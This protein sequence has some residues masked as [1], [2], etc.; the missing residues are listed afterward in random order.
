MARIVH[1]LVRGI[2]ALLIA[3]LVGLTLAQQAGPLAPS[4]LELTRFLPYPAL[5]GPAL[6]ALLLA[7]TLGWRWVLASLVTL[8]L[9][10]TLAMGLAWGR[11]QA[12]GT[13][14]R[15]MT[16]NIKAYKAL[17]RD[18]GFRELAREVALHQPDI[19]VTQDSHG[20]SRAQ[21]AA[22]WPGGRAFGMPYQFAADQ[23]IVASR[24]PLRDCAL[25]RT[26]DRGQPLGFVRCRVDVDGVVLNLVTTHFESPR[27][28]LN[29]ARR[30]GLEGADDWR[31]NH[32]E[33]LGQ[34]QALAHELRGLGAGARPLVVAGDL[35]APESSPVIRA[36]LGLGLRDAFTSAG[37]GYG[38]SYGHAFRLGF[39]FL[40]ID[41]ILVSPEL[42][43][44]DAFV[45]GAQASEHRPVI[46]DLRLPP[47]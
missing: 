27:S 7:C 44:A 3:S 22:L 35:N 21:A 1:H 8:A 41:H 31:Q 47:R 45:G 40:R 46:A 26:D 5:L 36:L 16:Y 10:V 23:Y 19:L 20:V 43:V 2:T 42:G 37:R 18:D 28:G 33:R 38:Y 32:A 24:Y 14:L 13:P 9:V 25:G 17:Q 29:A 39:S 11:P 12:G 4:W 34:A 15:L 30:E 6:L